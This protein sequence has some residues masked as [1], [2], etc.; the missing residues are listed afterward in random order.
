MTP[1]VAV[2]INNTDDNIANPS[3]TVT[4]TFSEAPTAFSLADTSA[5]AAR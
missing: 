4:F 3:G 2:A 1:T 5:P